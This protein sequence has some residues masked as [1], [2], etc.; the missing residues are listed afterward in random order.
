MFANNRNRRWRCFSSE[1][2]SLLAI[3]L[4]TSLSVCAQGTRDLGLQI[5][6]R[7]ENGQNTNTKLYGGSYAL[8]IGNSEYTNGWR[9]L[10]GVLDD[11]KAVETA[12]KNQGFEVEKIFDTSRDS[13]RFRLEFFINK[14]GLKADNRLLIY[15]AG[16]GHTEKI[17]TQEV[18]YLVM[19]DAPQPAKNL[20]LF[21]QRAVEMTEI[22][23]VAKR[24]KAKHVLFMFD[25]CFSG[26]LMRS[27]GQKPSQFI[28]AVT[29]K[30]VRQ[31]ITSGTADQLVPDKS[32]FR[33]MF[34]RALKGD[35]DFNGDGYVTGSEL[36][37]YLQQKVADYS[38]NT[39][40]PQYSK[41]RDITLDEGDFVFIPNAEPPPS[42]RA[43]RDA[44]DCA[45][46]EK[47]Y[48][49]GK[50]LLDDGKPDLALAEYNKAIGMNVKCA[51]PYLQ[52][53]TAYIVKKDLPRALKDFSKAI[54]V[55]PQNYKPYSFR[56]LLYSA[57]KDHQ[58]AIN[59][60]T[61]AIEL[62]T[63]NN[64]CAYSDYYSRG[65]SYRLLGQ[66][67]KAI[68][69]YTKA[70]E[71]RPIEAKIYQRR[72]KLLLLQKQEINLALADFD[73]AVSLDSTNA[74]YFQQRGVTLYFKGV[75]EKNKDY[76]AKGIIDLGKAI[77]LDPEDIDLYEVRSEAYKRIG[78]TKKAEDDRNKAEELKK[79]QQP[80]QK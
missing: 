9:K 43:E 77:E 55:E 11:V 26:T 17:G 15:F 53:G 24:I 72:G 62:C 58:S 41:I 18:G 22:E 74:G 63:R 73:K 54:E 32:I 19:S 28:T 13:F 48:S 7:N 46:V 44:N 20:E 36:G 8:I 39:Q 68:E 25:S 29:T 27:R 76:I 10:P 1:T 59:D 6:V 67:D 66:V 60:L 31:F 78:E 70:I 5:K 57:M 69:D 64:E 45:K 79:K 35:A 40:T 42:S 61:S 3:V 4:L 75:L 23:S 65:E 50:K 71:I 49:A 37:L 51:E 56:G 21:Q 16:H 52:S 38:N 33:V 80:Q 30:P 14:H 34:E 2:L 12:L 47:F